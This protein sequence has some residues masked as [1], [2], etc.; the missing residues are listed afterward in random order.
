MTSLILGMLTVMYWLRLSLRKLLHDS[1]HQP[2][3][4]TVRERDSDREWLRISDKLWQ[5]I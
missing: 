2:Y 1:H 4:V 3:S 5:C